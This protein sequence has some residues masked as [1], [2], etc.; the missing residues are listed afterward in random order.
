M[1]SNSSFFFF[2]RYI[3]KLKEINFFVFFQHMYLSKEN[4][5]KLYKMFHN[6]IA[7]SEYKNAEMSK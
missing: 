1:Y 6:T 2:N 7:E 3:V 4:L 5:T